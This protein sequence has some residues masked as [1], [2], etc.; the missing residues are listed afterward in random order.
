MSVNKVPQRIRNTI[1]VVVD[2]QGEQVHRRDPHPSVLDV[3][4][5]EVVLNSAFIVD[6]DPV[7]AEANDP[8]HA[9]ISK[10][11]NRAHSCPAATLPPYELTVW[12]RTN[13]RS[14]RVE[15]VGS[16]QV[17]VLGGCV[18]SQAAQRY[19]GRA[20]STQQGPEGRKLGLEPDGRNRRPPALRPG[21]R[22]TGCRVIHVAEDDVRV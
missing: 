11:A 17:S 9:G 18:G 12:R 14:G 13:V 6:V 16:A 10:Y 7:V 1:H 3:S 4:V 8:G 15:L 19:G 20:S 2:G 5:R 22:A 21:E